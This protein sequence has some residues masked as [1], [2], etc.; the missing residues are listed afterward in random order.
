MN[1]SWYLKRF[2]KMNTNEVLKRLKE[3]IWVYQSRYK[4]RNI[5]FRS[6][7]RFSKN[8]IRLKF[9]PL[10]VYKVHNNWK[11]YKIYGLEFDLTQKVNWYFSENDNVNWPKWHYSRINYRPGNPYGDVRINWELNR[12][13]FLPEMAITDEGLTKRLIDDWMNENPYLYGPSYLSSMEVALRWI[14]I[15]WAVSLFKKPLDKNFVQN[16]TGLAVASGKYINNLLSTHSSAGNH[17]IVESVGLFWIGKALGGSKQG[18]KWIGKAIGIIKEQIKRQINSD[19]SNKEQSFWYLG[20]VL[21]AAITYILLEEKQYISSEIDNRIEK[22]LE[23]VYEMTDEKGQFSDYGDRDDGYCF[24]TIREYHESPFPGLLNIGSLIFNRPDLARDSQRF[25]SQIKFWTKKVRHKDRL[26]RIKKKANRKT[27]IKNYNK[28]GMTLMKWNKGRLLFRH[29]SLG[30]SNMYG[31]G[32][33]DALSVIFSW[34]SIPVIIDLGSGQ[35]NGNQD[36]RNYFRSTI[37]HNTIEIGGK[38]QAKI[39]GPFLWEKSYEAWL[40]EAGEFPSLYADA[41]HNGYIKNCSVLHSRR[42]EWL[43]NNHIEII[44][45]FEGAERI[46]MKGAFHLGKCKNIKHEG[47]TIHVDFSKFLMLVSFPNAY[48]LTTYYGSENPF[49][50][51]RSTTYGSWEPIHSI[52]Y[53]GKTIKHTQFKI[54]IEIIE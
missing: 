46:P 10:P 5:G 17:L 6:Y 9:Y 31:H 54:T 22:M 35:Y 11:K 37:A 25:L 13:Q 12:L 34:E 14:S 26:H 15:Y 33:A 28:G 41:S 2:R 32:H 30:L 36:I 24:R 45:Y 21:A 1:W 39:L 44:D 42:I 7:Y 50:G 48:S 27:K 8:E 51:W 43:K 19:G 29:A 20:F 18:E 40:N 16:L 53:S 49:M 3:Y 23:F 4:Y 52:I 38:N 47:Q